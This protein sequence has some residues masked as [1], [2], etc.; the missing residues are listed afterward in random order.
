MQDSTARFGILVGVDGSAS[1]NAAVRWAGR[2]AALRHVPITLA[3]VIPP[4]VLTSRSGPLLE[5]FKA[6]QLQHARRVIDDA[7]RI[8]FDHVDDV[9]ALDVRTELYFSV[10][11]PSLVDASKEAQMLVVGRH[12][13]EAFNGHL[14]GSVSSGLLHHAHCP[15]AVIPDDDNEPPTDDFAHAPILL[16]VDGSPSAQ[17]ATAVAF[18]EASRRGVALV[19]LHAWSDVPVPRPLGTD[20][21]GYQADG[22]DVLADWLSRWQEQYPDVQVQRRLVCDRPAGTLAVGSQHAQLV[23]V[24]SHGRGGYAGEALGA[25]SSAVANSVFVPVIVARDS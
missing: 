8:L 2:D 7:R 13:L 9:T 25:V 10:I 16:G 1:S 21:P 17:R 11:V 23:V 24:G 18:E 22:N 12:G 3:H 6:A 15:V 14:L 5:R 20:W 4:P 19:A